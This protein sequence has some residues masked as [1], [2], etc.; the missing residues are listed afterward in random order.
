MELK[1]YKYFKFN[2]ILFFT[3]LIQVFAICILFVATTLVANES[4]KQTGELFGYPIFTYVG[5]LFAPIYEEM[6]FRG[7]I[8]GSLMKKYN[9][10]V[11]VVLSSLLFG[12][13]HFKNILFLD[14]GAVL[15]QILYTTLIAGPIFALATFK[16]KSLW[17]GTILHYINNLVNFLIILY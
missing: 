14:N 15:S 7:M 5:V 1:A 2:K 4:Y 6:I 3:P 8:F 16:T 13:W 9:L 17:A 10:F 11:S 12:L